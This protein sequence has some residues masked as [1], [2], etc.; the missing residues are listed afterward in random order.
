MNIHVLGFYKFKKISNFERNKI[1]I[2]NKFFDK[3][4]R[5]NIIISPEGINGTISG[6][7]QNINE[8]I[9]YIKK[10]FFIKKFDSTNLSKINYHLNHLFLA[11][12]K[13]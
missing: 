8:C 5:G 6:K 11:I 3:S 13:I 1:Q 10:I 7:K 12:Q 4:V 2:K 9:N